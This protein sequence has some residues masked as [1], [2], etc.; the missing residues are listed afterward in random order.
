MRCLSQLILR[1]IVNFWDI[2]IVPIGNHTALA[3]RSGRWK[4]AARDGATV[5]VRT[6][7]P[8][9]CKI[10]LSLANFLLICARIGIDAVACRSLLVSA[11][12]PFGNLFLI[13]V[14][15][16]SILVWHMWW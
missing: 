11:Y 5:V 10:V 14:A 16:D 7:V 15:I 6:I 1:T 13:S 12:D 9:S 4:I 8:S 2:E 3:S